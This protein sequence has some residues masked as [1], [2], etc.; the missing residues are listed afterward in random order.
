[1]A[2]DPLA[3]LEERIT[4]AIAHIEKLSGE[5]AGLEEKNKALVND[6]SRLQDRLEELEKQIVS[7]DAA[8]TQLSERVKDKIEGLLTRIEAFESAE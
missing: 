5:I 8:A 4:K 7:K 3:R 6:N 2:T 1:M